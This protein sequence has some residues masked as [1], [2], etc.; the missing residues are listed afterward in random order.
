VRVTLKLLATMIPS[1]PH[2]IYDVLVVST[3]LAMYLQIDDRQNLELAVLLS[4]RF[5]LAPR[6]R[7]EE[8]FT[9]Q[10]VLRNDTQSININATHTISFAMLI[11]VY[12][13]SFVSAFVV[14][15]E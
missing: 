9:H 7:K 3:S 1:V 14:L 8:R 11:L 12:S 5:I 2:R 10:R 6:P 4:H 13:C 15:A